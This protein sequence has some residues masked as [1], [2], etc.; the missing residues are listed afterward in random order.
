MTE[1]SPQPTA[2]LVLPQGLLIGLATA[3]WQIEGDVASRGRSIWDDLADVPGAIRG[4]VTGEPAT[5]HVHRLEEDLD[6]LASIGVDAYRFSISWPRVLPTGRGE[7]SAEG[8]GFY[9]RLVDGL[10]ARG[11]KPVATL[12]H[13]DLPST[14]QAEGGWPARSTAAAFA[15][16]AEIVGRH[17]GTRIDRWL[18]LNEP[19]CAA[20]LGYAAG[21]HAPAIRDGGASLAAAY[22]LMLGHG[23]ALQRLR[24]LGLTNIGIAPNLIPIIPEDDESADAAHFIDG[25]Q[26]RFWLDL[27]AGR[28]VPEDVMVGTK[29]LTDWSFVRDSDLPVIAAPIDWIGEN[30]YT[31]M[32][33]ALGAGSAEA[34]GQDATMFP[35]A[36]DVHFVPRGELT[37]MGWEVIPDGLVEILTRIARDLP[38][39]DIYVTENGAAMAETT[40]ADGVHDPRRIHYYRDHLDAVLR[41][42]ALGAP[43]KGYFGWSLLDNLEW[44]EGWSMRFGVVRVD[45]ETQERTLKDSAM[46]FRDRLAERNARA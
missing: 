38:D 18:T 8:I 42:R 7:I 10:I 4:G 41:A 5:D 45:P 12:Y 19:W 43:V 31:V 9:D 6:L 34:V 13:W 44:A 20:F 33:V 26:N 25:L 40:D 29:E 37:D 39:V 15:D 23:L 2:E 30:Y 24:D 22:H 32:R 27:L 16:Y 3:S 17:F 35:G 46:W 28:G 1:Q 21:I 14:L 36:G 11:I